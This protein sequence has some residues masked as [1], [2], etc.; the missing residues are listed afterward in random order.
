VKLTRLAIVLLLLVSLRGFG[1]LAAKYPNE[2]PGYRFYGTA[3]WHSLV[4]SVSTIADIRR[5]LGNPD[6]ATSA[7]PIATYPGDSRV[8]SA[9]LVFARLMQDWDVLIY[10][11]KT[12]D[13]AQVPRLC[14]VDLLPKKRIPFGQVTFP[15]AFTRRHAE[16]ADA[17]WD[18]YSDGSGLR[19]EVYTTK[20]PY[21]KQLPGDLSRISYGKP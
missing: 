1:Q 11:S 4:P 20:P 9:V 5:L 12:C 21:G 10:V 6:H 3:K 17:G 7:H 15:S 18:E 16:N 13:K 14:S 8:N 2:L 19:Y